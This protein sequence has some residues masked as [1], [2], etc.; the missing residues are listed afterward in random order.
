MHPSEL[1]ALYRKVDGGE[2]IRKIICE[3]MI[4]AALLSMSANG[5][6][7]KG[8]EITRLTLELKTFLRIK[9]KYVY[10]LEDLKRKVDEAYR[11]EWRAR[12]KDV[13]VL[14][15]Q[16]RSSA[17]EVVKKCINSHEKCL[18]DRNV[19]ILT[20][21]NYRECVSFPPWIQEKIDAGII[22]RT[23]MSDLLRL[24]LLT[25]YGGTWI[26]ATVFLSDRPADYMLESQLFLFQT[27]KPGLDGHTTAIS[28]W[29]MTSQADSRILMLAREMLYEYWKNNNSLIDYFLIHYFIQIAIEQ[30]PEE[31]GRVVPASNEPPHMLLLSEGRKDAR[32][33]E[34]VRAQTPVHKLTYKCDEERL[35]ELN[36]MIDWISRV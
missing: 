23:H 13:W 5:T 1:R 16:G 22:T 8:L 27:L 26:D 21:E 14:W 34:S 20:E 19:H 17:P 29:F 10:N 24:E 11:S 2:I 33:I 12:S 35:A 6:S 9:K 31:W 18:K 4:S 32:W 36:E 30:Y 7:R 3:R 25:K 15:L 28:S